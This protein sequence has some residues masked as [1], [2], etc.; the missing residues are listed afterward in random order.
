M[1]H[2]RILINV[3]HPNLSQSTGNQALMVGVSGMEDVTVRDLYA[4]YPDW[5]IDVALEQQLLVEHDVIV[6][7]HP[8]YWGSSPALLKEWLDRVLEMGF[9]FPPGKGDALKGKVWQQAVTAGGT[10]DNYDGLD[11]RCTLNELL[12]PFRSAARFCQM[13]WRDPFFV[14]GVVPSGVNS[15]DMTT[16]D[17]LDAAGRRYRDLLESYQAG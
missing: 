10:E 17:R 13:K 3:V 1:P 8:L 6:F 5:R 11:G 2:P 9:A 15:A 14:F 7:Q 16:A 4:E 12:S